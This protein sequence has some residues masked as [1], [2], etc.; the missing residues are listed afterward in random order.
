[1]GS[2]SPCAPR[3]PRVIELFDAAYNHGASPADVLAELR[4]LGLPGELAEG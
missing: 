1:M 2:L 4:S 3:F